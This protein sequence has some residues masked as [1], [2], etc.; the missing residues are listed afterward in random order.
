V[1]PES[2]TA[3]I[4]WFPIEA[5]HI[6]VFA[7]AIGDDVSPDGLTPPTFGIAGPHFDPNYPLRPRPGRPWIA[8]STL[9]EDSLTG[10]TLHA[11]QQFHH[12]RQVRAGDVLHAV[13]FARN[14]W[15]K[16]GRRGLL[17]FAET[18]TELRDASDELVI[19]ARATTVGTAPAEGA[20]P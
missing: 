7:G 4:D 19:M 5:G 18:I 15:Q 16:Q 1:N 10:S 8:S 13:S 6:H 17:Y 12:H 11:E 2:S 14:A 9:A 20:T 3:T